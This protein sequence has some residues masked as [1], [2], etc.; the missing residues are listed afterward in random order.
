M[1]QNKPIAKEIRSLNL[2]ELAALYGESTKVIK[3]W[4]APHQ[5]AIGEKFGQR[6]MPKQVAII[7]DKIG[8]PASLR[9]IE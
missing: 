1:Q 6:Y 7:F 3:K 9:I 8:V 2:K 4:L 5:K